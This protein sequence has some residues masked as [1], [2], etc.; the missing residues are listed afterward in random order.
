MENKLEFEKIINTVFHNDKTFPT[1]ILY[2]QG[3]TKVVQVKTPT[4]VIVRIA[5]GD[6]SSYEFQSTLLTELAG[7]DALTSQILYWE[8]RELGNKPYG[9]Q[10]QTYVP[11]EPVDH[12]PDQKGAKAIVNTAYQLHKRLC[13]A[14]TKVEITSIPKTHDLIIQMLPMVSSCP[15][16]TAAEKLVKQH[17]YLELISQPEQH[18]IYGDLWYKNILLEFYGN[19]TTVRFIDIDPIVLGPSILQPAILFASYFLFSAFILEPKEPD[20][21]NLDDLISYWPEPLNKKDILLLMQVFPIG[22]GLL[23]TVQLSQSNMDF[24]G[25][26]SILEPFEKSIQAIEKMIG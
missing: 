24:N 19:K 12:Y 2:E 1:K 8:T 13:S 7:Q 18:L 25:R 20:T 10:V 26:Q 3:T 15:I 5:E 6:R 9:I 11:G 23:K 17:R 14:S 4:P 22:L 21:F 16:K